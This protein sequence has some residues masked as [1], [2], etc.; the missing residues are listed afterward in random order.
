MK[1]KIEE[2]LLQWADNPKRMPL[3]LQ[4]ARQ[5]GK[6]FLLE[7]LGTTRFENMVHVNLETQVSIAEMFNGDITPQKVVH[8]L[9]TVFQTPIKPHKTLIILD[10]IQCSERAL[11]S[12][13]MFCEDAPEYAVAAAGSLLGVAINREKFSFP[14]GKVHELTL[15]PLDFE[16]FL[17]A[18]GDETLAKTIREHCTTFNPLEDPIHNKAIE[19]YKQ[20]LILGGMPAVV[21]NFIDTGSI[22][23]PTEIQNR[24]LNEYSADMAKYASPAQAVKIRGCYN[25]IPVQ[26]AKENRKF[27]YKLVQRGGTATIFGESLDWLTFAGLIVKC[28]LI[29]NGFMPLA[30]YVNMSDFKIY[31]GDV[32]LLT[33]K[34]GMA[35]Q[36][37]LSENEPDN[38][39][40]GGLTENYVAQA[41]ATNGHR[42][43]YWKNKNTAEVDFVLQIQDKIIPVEVKKGRHTKSTSL[44]MFRKQFNCENAI[45]ISKKNFGNTDGILSIPCY[46]VF[47]I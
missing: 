14:V 12:L 27:Q 25:S 1:R 21:Q 2:K 15:F 42:L 5:V 30:A 37:I 13:K 3:L 20:Y 22:V 46:A 44:T 24:I 41:L 11:M 18:C 29:D 43:F 45:R 26:L 6:S 23:L 34:S 10:E 40:M 35:S 17:W 31:M 7:W 33:L 39:F 38:G 9:E 32:G 8:A 4:G 28:E 47:C 19:R 36:V 16:E